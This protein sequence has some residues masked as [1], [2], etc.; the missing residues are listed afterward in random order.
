M[1]YICYLP[2]TAIALSMLFFDL[3]NRIK[4]GW[5][6]YIICICIFAAYATELG[7]EIKS[8]SSCNYYSFCKEIAQHLPA[9]GTIYLS[10]VPDPY[11]GLLQ[12]TPC[13]KFIEYSPVTRDTK[14]IAKV[15]NQADYIIWGPVSGTYSQD[16]L[17]Y[18]VIERIQK[19]S[20][21]NVLAIT[22][23]KY[24]ANVIKIK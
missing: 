6:V 19:S 2:F 12:T 9:K 16:R 1:W 5:L 14:T 24:S 13:L 10:S 15:I 3:N 7:T 17:D 8:I 22:A 20:A 18:Q 21:K 23:G 4:Y 11:F